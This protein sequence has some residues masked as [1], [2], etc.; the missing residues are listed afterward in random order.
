M[1]HLLTFLIALLLLP[2]FAQQKPIDLMQVVP[3]DSLVRTGTLESGIK[4]YI[5]KN[6]KDPQRANFHIV[7]D[8]G[9]IQEEDNQNGLAHF[10]EH[11]AFNG[12]KNFPNN[13]MIDYFKSI[14]VAF[15]ENLNAGT[16]Q[17]FTTYM[18]QNVPITRES[19]I[20]STLLALH[21]WAGFI[22]LEEKE[23][24]QERGVI[25]EEWR[26]YNTAQMRIS[27]KQKNTIFNNSIYAKRNVIGNEEVLKSF[28]YEDLSSFYHK[29]Y[30][31]DM[32]AFIIVGDFDVDQMEAK[33]KKTMSDIKAFDVK[34]PKNKVI[35]QDNEQPLISIATD[36]EAQ[37]TSVQMLFRH[38]PIAEKYANRILAVKTNLI[39]NMISIMFN[40]RMVDISRKENAPFLGAGASYQNVVEPF[41]VFV[42]GATARNNEALTTLEAIYTEMLRMKRGGFVT[43]EIERAKTNILASYEQSAKNSNDRRNGAFI[44]MCMSNFIKNTPYATPEYYLETSKQLLET[45]DINEINAVAKSLIRDNNGAILISAPSSTTVPVDADVHTTLEKV[46]ASQIELFKDD[47]KV[48]PLVDESKIIAGEVVSEKTGE[49]DAKIWTLSNGVRVILKK[50]DFKADEVIMS[51][52]QMGGMTAVENLDDLASLQFYPTF[53]GNAGLGNFSQ[54]DLRKALTG[55]VASTRTGFGQLTC[56]INGNCAP[57]DIETMLQLTYLNITAPRFEQSDFNVV[58]NH[59]KSIIPN[60]VNTPDFIFYD[61][62]LKTSS[63]NSPRTMLMLPSMEKLEKV[64]LE[65]MKASYKAQFANANGMTFIFAG[66]FDEATLKPLV[67]KYL[68]SLPATSVA[69]PRSG[70]YY[71]KGVKGVIK[72]E[73]KTKMET[74]KVTAMV[75]Y[76]GN[77]DYNLQDRTN[78]NAIKHI[79]DNRYTKSIR[80][81]SGGT[82]SVSVQT[83]TSQYPESEF[84]VTINFTTDTSKINQLMP[85]VYKEID[86]LVKGNISPESINEYKEFSIKKFAENNINNQVW[87]N[88]MSDWFVWK[89]N[90]YTDY[91]KTVQ[92]ITIETITKT[93]AKTFGQDNIV[94]VIQLP[95]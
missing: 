54:S 15:G 62:L 24:D 29:W 8:V 73:F 28:T 17:E 22:S 9:A 46:N 48:E 14:G 74:P 25:I 77:F 6:S 84:A 53:A 64:S 43:S 31:P 38:K 5:R 60:I 45:I 50:T 39:H 36:P 3:N 51:S 27:E 61:Q 83:V 33:L 79:L 47:A 49:F 42:V 40:E 32:Q 94:T 26:M 88:Y 91:V 19:I 58:M 68:G 1:K 20:D 30:R 76:S 69:A 71:D 37:Q 81:E 89:N 90:D 56:G 85:I 12:S 67:E 16:S 21:D 66:N 93:A 78:L 86:D 65:R 13:S 92:G 34:T 2:S 55:K 41:N 35:I 23:I 72:N 7:Y 87:L 63:N 44:N 10:L 11:M 95:E 57:K 4:Y 80:E 52:S 75:I 18:I 59:M 70:K 82:Y